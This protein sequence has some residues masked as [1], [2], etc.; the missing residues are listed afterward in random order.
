MGLLSADDAQAACHQV[1]RISKLTQMEDRVQ[2]RSRTLN[3][4]LGIPADTEL[5]GTILSLA[6]GKGEHTLKGVGMA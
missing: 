1:V 3:T 6:L 5:P 2:T 4:L